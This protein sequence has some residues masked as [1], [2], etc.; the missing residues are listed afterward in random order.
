[1]LFKFKPACKA[2]LLMRNGPGGMVVIEMECALDREHPG[3]HCTKEG[4]KWATHDKVRRH[5]EEHGESL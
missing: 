5:V 4:H 3:L 2:K 1:M